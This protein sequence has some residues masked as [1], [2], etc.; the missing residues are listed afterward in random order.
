MLGLCQ[1]LVCATE[2]C[3]EVLKSNRFKQLLELVLLMGN[4]LNTGSRNAQS[5]GFDI[6]FLPKVKQ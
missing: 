6:S 4:Y 3:E 2:A 1:D 5:L